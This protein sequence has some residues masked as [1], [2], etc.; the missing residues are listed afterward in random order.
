[1]ALAQNAAGWSLPSGD[2]D[3]EKCIAATGDSGVAGARTPMQ[4]SAVSMV[5]MPSTVPLC[6]CVRRASTTHVHVWVGGER[7]ASTAREVRA[8]S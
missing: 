2:I 1:L 7:E 3:I 5:S 4:S 8:F 6:G